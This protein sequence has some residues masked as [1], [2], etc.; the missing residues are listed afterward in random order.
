MPFDN[1]ALI[2]DYTFRI[3]DL[4]LG[5]QS[6]VSLGGV[7]TVANDGLFGKQGGVLQKQVTTA[8]YS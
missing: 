7:W 2:T 1:T 4:G 8:L 3:K 5:T 6:D